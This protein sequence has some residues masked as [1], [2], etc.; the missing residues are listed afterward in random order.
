MRFLIDLPDET[1]SKLEQRAKR[2][3]RTRKPEAEM[4]IT[5]A[6][7]MEIVRKK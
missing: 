6:V 4:I 7:Q 2:N 1:V 3:K 5:E